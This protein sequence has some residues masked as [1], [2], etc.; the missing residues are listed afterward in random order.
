[1]LLDEPYDPVKESLALDENFDQETHERQTS[2]YT[3]TVANFYDDVIAQ[4]DT[5]D[6]EIEAKA[7]KKIDKRA[8]R[9]GK[10]K[11]RKTYLR[12][13]ARLLCHQREKERQ[14]RESK[15]EKGE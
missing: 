4:L 10:K 5:E 11:S 2:S 1:M 12:N 7:L 14:R 15:P 8:K 6:L 3:P 13:L 9:R